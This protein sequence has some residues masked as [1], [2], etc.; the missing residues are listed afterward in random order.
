M[1]TAPT[2]DFKALMF[3]AKINSMIRERKYKYDEFDDQEPARELTEDEKEER[4]YDRIY[5]D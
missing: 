3:Q 5:R 2:F 1:T 4:E